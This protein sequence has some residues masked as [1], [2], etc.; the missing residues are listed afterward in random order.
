[1][2]FLEENYPPPKKYTYWDAKMVALIISNPVYKGEF[3]AH[4]RKEIKVPLSTGPASLTGGAVKT[5]TRRV[6]RPREEWIIVP[7]PAVVCAEEWE[8]ANK[9]LEKNKQMSRR[10]GKESFLLTGLIH[11]ATCNHKYSGGRRKRIGKTGVRYGTSWYRCSAANSGYA[12]I[13]ERTGC[14][15]SQ[16]SIRVIDDAV[17]SLIYQVLLDPQILITALEKEF[18]GERNNQTSRQISFLEN[19]INESNIEDDKLYKAYL[20]GVFNETEYAG[21]RRLVKE[22]RQ[23]LQAELQQLNG[24][25]ISPEKLKERKQEILIVCS[26]ATSNGLAQNAPFEVKRNIIKTILERIILNVNEGWF[27]LEGVIHGRYYLYEDG[28][29]HLHH[30]PNNMIR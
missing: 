28:K 7:V 2:N 23:R 19:Q 9:V 5:I 3:I 22:N 17:W 27:E 15:Q 16:I 11:C 26:H 4:N 29:P 10:N 1:V 25:L 18:Q 21:R 30:N 13:R 6:T 8:L 14:D 20:A 24:N 12:A